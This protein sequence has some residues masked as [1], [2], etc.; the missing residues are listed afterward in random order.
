[1]IKKIDL[2]SRQYAKRQLTWFK[3][4]KKIIWFNANQTEKIFKTVRNF[5]TS[6]NI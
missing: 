2:E 4:D 5:L 3:R 6:R 1:M